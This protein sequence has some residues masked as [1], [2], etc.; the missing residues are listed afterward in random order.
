MTMNN[1]LEKSHVTRAL[2]TKDTS[3]ND[4]T[5]RHVV[6]YHKK[7]MGKNVVENLGR[8]L[9]KI[10]VKRVSKKKSIHF[11]QDHESQ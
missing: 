11:F 7:I 1:H 10:N 9:M 2:S 6:W 4:E 3:A 5:D 8:I